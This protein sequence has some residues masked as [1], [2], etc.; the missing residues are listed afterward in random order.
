MR[1]IF[2]ILVTPTLAFLVLWGLGNWLL[3][4]R[5][6]TW[7]LQE[8]QNY[9]K[10]S[11]PV[12]IQADRLRIRVLR[13]SL[14]LENIRIIPKGE[15][16]EVTEEIRVARAR[17][18]LD[19]FTLLGGR[20]NLSALVI[21]A[22]ETV[23]NLDPLL[24]SDSKPK[25]LPL[26]E[27]FSITEQIPL[28]KIL[29]QNVHIL[30]TSKKLGIHVEASNSGLL[31]TNMGKNITAKLDTPTLAV[32]LKNVGQFSGSLDSHLY[33]TRQSLRVLQLGVRLDNSEFLARGELTDFRNIAIKPSGVLNLS[34][35]VA[36]ADLYKELKE[37][38]PDMALPKLAGTLDTDAEVR[39]NGM[40]DIRGKADISTHSVIVDTF[41]LGDAHIEGEYKDKGFTFSEI[42]VSHPAGTATL[43]KSQLQLDENYGFKSTVKVDSLDLQKL[44]V[45]LDLA[46]IPVG[47][48]LQGNLPCTGQILPQFY[49]Q[50]DD[51]VLTGQ[52]L[53]VKSEN[54]S[55]G[56]EIVNLKDMKVT[57]KAKVTMDAVTYDANLAIGSSVGTSDGII[58]FHKGFKINYKTKSLDMKDIQNLSHLK[59]VGSA[60][61]EGSTQGNAST[62]TMDM[63]LNV[64]NFIFEDFNLGNAITNLKMRKGHLIFSDIAGAQNKTQYIG[65]LDIDLT[66][67]QLTG[68]F[69]APTAELE[70]IAVIL[71]GIYKFPFPIAGTGSAKA[72]VDGPL[73]FWKLNY[74]L[75]S[76]FKNVSAS[77]E[78]FDLLHF[79]VDATNGNIKARKVQLLK[80]NSVANVTGGI[81]SDKILGLFVDAKNW[82]LEESDMI[83]AVSTGVFGNLNASAEIKNSF[84]EA[85]VNIKGALTE[86]VL[87]DQEIDN[88]SFQMSIDRKSLGG[89][90]SLFGDKVQ[91]D[92]QIPFEHT[93]PLRIQMKTN[94][95]SFS[96]LLALI[97]GAN[98]A[99][100][101]ESSLTSNIDLRSDSGD[102]FKSTGKVTVQNIYLKRGAS[103][104]SNTG[105]IEVLTEN[106]T[107]TFKNFLLRG[108]QNTIQIKGANF[109]AERMNFGI[110]ARTDLRLL[111]IFTP[112]LD[113][114]GGPLRISATVSGKVSK[115]EI[116]GTANL[117]NAFVKLKGFPHPLERLQSNVSFSQSRIII[118][119]LKGQIAGGTMTG[120]GSVIIN[121][122]KDF[123][124]SVR[125]HL[126]NISLNVPDR[127]HTTGE[128]DLLFSGKWFPFVLSGTY[129]VSG[130]IFEREFIE[131][132]SGVANIQQSA[133]LPKVLRDTQ[134]EPV[135]LDIQVN[136]DKPLPVKNSLFDGSVS[137][138]IAVKGAPTNPVLLGKITTEKRS[139][140]I[141]KDRQFDIQTANV[142]FA[143]PNQ[144]N[145]NLYVTATSRVNEYDVSLFASGS[146]KNPTIKLTSVPPL[147]EQDIVSL[148]ALGVTSQSMATSGQ[149]KALADQAGLE[150]AGAAFAKEIN[151]PLESTLGLNLS[152][153]SQYDSTRNISVPKITLSRRLTEKVKISGSRQVG[154]VSGY[155]V[156]LE[157]LLNPNW[158]AVGSF[159]NKNLYDNSVLQNTPVE[160]ESIFGLDLEFKREF[161]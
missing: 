24:K 15:F 17:V 112:F 14:A 149:S 151:K 105:P 19:F 22:P 63:N 36:L 159:E 85:R 31:L 81:S 80:N 136:L 83:S 69:S 122:P 141:F 106:G 103:S 64:R 2:W 73:N 92:F 128:A 52:D 79:N 154:D 137:G 142:D 6:E 62:A 42:S 90:V 50:C 3:I 35:K 34:A 38:K 37:L 11:L 49:V 47:V 143:D 120:D 65:N 67:S 139:K 93:S 102:L 32:S 153:T 84:N 101:Y 54:N 27:I 56:S 107:V 46:S 158:T 1:R 111:Q 94:Q 58:D 28:Q 87:E 135:L 13:T 25:P 40:N 71:E 33:L 16:A 126:D 55:K 59:M 26:D 125:A 72:Q 144:I 134:F 146:A 98:L 108:P 4:P 7:A 124:V 60:S 155:D 39:F 86:T 20:L 61:I 138:H 21:D 5:L 97:G 132:G 115:P 131:G 77:N 118:N 127:V 89:Q 130:G 152:V 23:I 70:D 18:H 48:K 76:A 68:A 66:H 145:P 30:V 114:L 156:K 133:Y 110:E 99:N 148:I 129:R 57:G 147:S 9:S 140:L 75:D 109:T 150:V 104:I 74:K 95:W 91:G 53:W 160:T 10:S 82:R 117:N 12:E 121:G 45:S 43:N 157:Y 119:D 51:G 88:S 123:P 96:S 41:E 44:F 161:K 113:D 116:L 78:N 8:L 29:L 100:E